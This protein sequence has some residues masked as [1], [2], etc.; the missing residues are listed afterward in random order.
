[1]WEKMRGMDYGT[2]RSYCGD[3][4]TLGIENFCLLFV[5]STQMFASVHTNICKSIY[6]LWT[7]NILEGLGLLLLLLKVKYSSQNIISLYF[8]GTENEQPVTVISVGRTTRWK[9]TGSKWEAQLQEE[10]V[11]NTGFSLCSKSRHEKEI[12]QRK[13]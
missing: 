7:R 13:L 12:R 10:A 1:M 8:R 5:C 2:Q 6:F 4:Y 9:G 11:S 3:K